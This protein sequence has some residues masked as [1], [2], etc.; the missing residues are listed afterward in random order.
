MPSVIGRGCKIG[1]EDVCLIAIP[2]E[3]CNLSK[4]RFTRQFYLWLFEAQFATDI[5][6]NG[7]ISRT[8][9]IV[10]VV[11]DADGIPAAWIGLVEIDVFGLR[12][13]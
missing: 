8:V 3:P 5:D 13:S 11:I 4:F 2:K 1:L 6:S 7:G 9:N 12:T 10:F